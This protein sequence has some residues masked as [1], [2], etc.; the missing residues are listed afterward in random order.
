MGL[1]ASPCFASGPKYNFTDPHLEDEFVNVYK[2][3]GTQLKGGVRISSST[4][5]NAIMSTATITNLRGVTDGSD[6]CAGCIGQY[7]SSSTAQ[8]HAVASP[9]SGQYFDIVSK[10]IPAGDWDLSGV[11]NC[12]TDACTV[13]VFIGGISLTSGNSSTGFNPGDTAVGGPLFTATYDVGVTIPAW[14]LSHTNSETAY[15]KAFVTYSGVCTVSC[16]GRLSARR[17]R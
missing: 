5:T 12:N 8:G 1:L 6:G 13:T 14:R 2:D 3:I 9:A 16:Y 15:L 17:M 10:A 4:T 11:T 7:I